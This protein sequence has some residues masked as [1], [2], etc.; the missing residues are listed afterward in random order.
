MPPVST[1]LRFRAMG[2]DVHVIVVGGRPEAAERAQARIDELEQRWSRFIEDS[3]I[4]ELNRRA[5]EPMV[6]SVDTIDLVTKAIEAW[7]ITGAS[8]DPLVLRAVLRAG[9]TRSFEDLLAA[10]G[11][12]HSAFEN[13]EGLIVACTDIEVVGNTV[14]LPAGTGFD[15]GGI[16]KGLAADIVA[17]EAMA[18]GAAGVCIN[19][20]GDLRVAGEAPAVGAWTVAVDHEWSAEPIALIGLADGAVAT[21]TTLRRRWQV[22]GE[23]RHHLIDPATGLPSTSDVNTATVVSGDA[24][25]AEVLAK[26][27]LLRGSRHPFDLVDGTGN[28]AIAVTDTGAVLHTEG[29]EAFLGG[30]ALPSQLA[31]AS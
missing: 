20:G 11:L 18:G 9:Y 10:G 7:R 29:L 14:R 2:T 30:R 24:W 21:S 13:A 31:M 26:A 27:V 28:E 16:G 5:G 1:E 22:D 8:F 12:P 6:V 23:N 17:R 25:M 3:E 15:A 19:L 4:S